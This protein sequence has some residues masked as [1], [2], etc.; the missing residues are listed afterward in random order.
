MTEYWS[1]N[2]GRMSQ[3][4]VM[5]LALLIDG[6]NTGHVHA[7]AIVSRAEALGRP[8]VRRVYTGRVGAG[9]WA[10][11]PRFQTV[12]TGDANAANAADIALA[13]DAVDLAHGGAVD[14][15]VI[16]SSDHD[17]SR[18]AHRLGAD[19]FPVLGMGERHAPAGFRAACSEF[20]EVDRG[21]PE[22][23]P[24]CRPEAVVRP[25]AGAALSPVDS[26][27]HALLPAD[28][29]GVLLAAVGRAMRRT[30]CLP[31]DQGARSWSHY[32]GR[33]PH[34]YRL[35]GKGAAMKVHRTKGV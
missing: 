4:G 7:D 19:G 1:P 31:S 11:D 20:F 12:Y 25:P 8:T 35:S 26:A 6:E 29:S 22:P 2:T 33:H 18:L 32:M 16:V 30:G 24:A 23:S 10:D 3:G 9:G 34:L 15:F 28:G 5:R 14:G 21:T 17:F 13:I 27:I